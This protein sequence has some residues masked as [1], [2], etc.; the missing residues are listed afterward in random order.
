MIRSTLA[1]AMLT[2]TAALPAAAESEAVVTLGFGAKLAPSYF[3]SDDYELGPT[4]SLPLDYLRLGD[5]LTIGSPD[6]GYAPTGFRIG[7]SFRYVGDREAADH[8]EL[9]GLED[10]DAA[11]E[12][13]VRVGYDA[14]GYRAYAALR[15]GVTGHESL[16]AEIGAD[17]VVQASDRLTLNAG[18]RFLFGSDR[19]A[20]TYFGVTATESAASGLS[21][22][23]A[24]G[25][26]LSAGVEIGATYQFNDDWGLR[27]AI[28]YER[29]MGDAADSPITAQGS[30][31]QGSA[32]LTLTRRVTFG[33]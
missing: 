4:G 22:F 23:D 10:I 25:G 31:T 26:L 16:V 33:F 32:S 18:P 1:A 24:G 3:G 13:G 29:L 28:G 19:Y 21:A 20:A 27:G 7:G 12:L 17:A 8:P 6:P 9:A 15:Y 2:L 30:R 14:P 11:L 5:S